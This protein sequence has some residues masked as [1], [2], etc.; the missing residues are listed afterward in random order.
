M[1]KIVRDTH[2]TG[3]RGVIKF[4]EYCNQH[5]PYIIFREVLKHDFGIDGEVEIV[6]TSEDGKKIAT[7][8][9]LKVQIKST[10]SDQGY[11]KN[12]TETS[13]EF[14]AKKDDI[15]YWSKYKLDVLLVIFDGRSDMLYC[16]KINKVDFFGSKKKSIPISF[17]K[18]T[19][20]LEFGVHDFV[21][22]YS[23]DFKS[24][25]NFDV[26]EILCTNIIEFKQYPKV[27]YTYPSKFTN[28]KKLF[29]SLEK[30][31]DYPPFAIYDQII[32]SF[33]DLSIHYKKFS[34]HSLIDQK[35]ELITFNEISYDKVLIKHYVELLKEYIKKLFRDK[36]LWYNKDYNRFYF[37]KPKD[38][39]T[40]QISY[41][42]RKQKRKLDK[43]VV[44]FYDQY[45]KD[46]FYRHWALEIEFLFIENKPYL[47]LNPKYFFTTDGKTPLIPKKITKFTNFLTARELNENVLNQIHFYLDYL[48]GGENLIPIW[49]YDGI[50]INLSRNI[51][52]TVGFSIPLDVQAK[53]ETPK[54]AQINIQTD[55]FQ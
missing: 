6:Q 43:A 7:G 8:E 20:W 49:N 55:L 33:C 18:T 13:F 10:N 42:T 53:N 44:N 25:V 38:Y 15:E 32:Y 14:F 37:P 3:E 9:I 21:K 47:L 34:D 26:K 4:S 36:M 12:E 24:R 29:A 16:K 54:G 48:S 17:N 52:F 19:N 50:Q 45:D 31:I 27:I 11:I 5:K 23:S 30:E 2:I 22:K 39:D 51:E 1:G 46:G 41:T 28:K 35:A 40:R